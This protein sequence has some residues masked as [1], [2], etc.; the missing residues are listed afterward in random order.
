[1]SVTYAEALDILLRES[2]CTVRRW[3]KTNHGIAYTHDDDWGIEIPPARGPVS[4]AVGCHEIGHQ[5]M[6][7]F[8]A[9]PR[10]LE[11]IEAEEF[12]LAQFERFELVGVEQ[13][14]ANM[15]KHLRYA[16][17]KAVRRGA[18]ALPILTR[19]PDWVWGEDAGDLVDLQR[20]KREEATHA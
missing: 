5:L 12:A 20:P 7:R 10:W 6:H 16:A 9:L 11:E 2:G 15:A 18:S 17:S 3:R 13:A 4:F 14:R 8:N 1:M 19:Y